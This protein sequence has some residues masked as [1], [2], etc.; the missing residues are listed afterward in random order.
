MPAPRPSFT[1][2]PQ[3]QK[4]ETVSLWLACQFSLAL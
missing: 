1:F 4:A 2:L 3:N